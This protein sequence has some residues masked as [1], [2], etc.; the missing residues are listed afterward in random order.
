MRRWILLCL[1]ACAPASSFAVPVSYDL[2]FTA[3]EGPSGT[4]GFDWDAATLTM[5]ALSWDFG[6]GR[7]G[8]MLDVSLANALSSGATLGQLLFELITGNDLSIVSNNIGNVSIT[9]PLTSFPRFTTFIRGGEY[10]FR[11]DANLTASAGGIA[12]L[13]ST[14]PPTNVP[15]PAT[16]ALL[17][18]G[19]A[20]LIFRR[21]RKGNQRAESHGQQQQGEGRCHP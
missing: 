14:P 17:L 18:T 15:E 21:P 12:A 11:T 19:L 9:Q 20:V 7:T 16:L 6:G 10:S 3:T 8:G 1:L 4:G 5:T 13:A 2:T